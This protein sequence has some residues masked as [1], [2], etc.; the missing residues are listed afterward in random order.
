M[1]NYSNQ[2]TP[3]I[4]DFIVI[5]DHVL[6][7]HITVEFVGIIILVSTTTMLVGPLYLELSILPIIHP[8]LEVFLNKG[9]IM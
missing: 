9:I 8:T 6:D 4:L 2:T 1:C 5:L 3:T 7:D